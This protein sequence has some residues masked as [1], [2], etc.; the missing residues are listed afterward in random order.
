MAKKLN[1][2]PIV[3]LIV[4]V[5]AG[6]GFYNLTCTGE[7]RRATV[8]I[9]GG[10]PQIDPVV[11]AASLHDA[12]SVSRLR[13]DVTSPINDR[14][15][16][17]R[18][19]G[20]D[21][22][23]IEGALV[24]MDDGH[25]FVSASA[26]EQ[27]I[28]VTNEFGIVVCKESRLGDTPWIG[29]THCGYTPTNVAIASATTISGS[30]RRLDILLRRGLSLSIDVR[31]KD[32]SGIANVPLSVS[33][34]SL[35]VASLG[36]GTAACESG[37]LPGVDPRI[38]VWHAATDSNGSAVISGLESSNYLVHTPDWFSLTV[39]CAPI[40]HAVEMNSSLIIEAEELFGYAFHI[41]DER[42]VVQSCTSSLRTPGE[43][44]RR[45]HVEAAKRRL[46]SRLGADTLLTVGLVAEYSTPL[47][48]VESV[49]V[50]GSTSRIER[51]PIRIDL[52][53]VAEILSMP[54]VSPS[55][56]MARVKIVVDNMSSCADDELPL[57]GLWM[58]GFER[59]GFS[60]EMRF[61]FTSLRVNEWKWVMPGRHQLDDIFGFYGQG[62]ASEWFDISPGESKEIRVAVETVSP[63]AEI[64][65]E[66]RGQ[67][68]EAPKYDITV[69]DKK[70]Q[71]VITAI[72]DQALPIQRRLPPAEYIFQYAVPGFAPGEVHYDLAATGG[73]PIVALR[74]LDR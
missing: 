51:F 44:V 60:A 65:F 19:V 70:S 71:A 24:V 5:I 29:A 2:N 50:D 27:V 6:V 16:I 40:D 46:T 30:S 54:S 64:V 15:L 59:F 73:A 18:V 57:I 66:W 34:V 31:R 14:D 21:D 7:T 10:A 56:S 74:L 25:R 63:V 62:A 35:D 58:K 17:V 22:A 48:V 68:F 55:D 11:E 72:I 1:P 52:L 43:A 38:A 20:D 42:V 4:T 28:G 23:P 39:Q 45:R 8:G 12:A 61:A 69:V 26:P 47:V 49:L 33:P 9:P 37:A 53:D 36:Q 41:V 13:A 67:T 3:V 32:G